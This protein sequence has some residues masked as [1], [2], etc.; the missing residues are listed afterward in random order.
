MNFEQAAKAVQATPQQLAQ[1]CIDWYKRVHEQE[2]NNEK[3]MLECATALKALGIG[4]IVDTD[5]YLV[6][7][8]GFNGQPMPAK[9]LFTRGGIEAKVFDLDNE[10]Y[11]TVTG[12]MWDHCSLFNDLRQQELKISKDRMMLYEALESLMALD[13]YGDYGTA[14]YIADWVYK[15]ASGEPQPQDIFADRELTEEDLANLGL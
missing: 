2:A 3:A 7:S 4:A 13:V 10:F 14:F 15:L 8:F 9:V 12:D 1:S 11:E 6:H 5:G